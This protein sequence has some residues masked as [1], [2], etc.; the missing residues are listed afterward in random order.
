MIFSTLVKTIKNFCNPILLRLGKN[1]R[2]KSSQKETSRIKSSNFTTK[3]VIKTKY[4]ENGETILVPNI[5]EVKSVR[6][7]IIKQLQTN[8]AGINKGDKPP[9]A[10][11][12]SV[13][14]NIPTQGAANYK[15]KNYCV[16]II[17]IAC[18][19]VNFF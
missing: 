1:G 19:L 9:W 10:T 12:L 11:P 8:S 18:F 13:R 6:Q 16:E 15:F 3:T 17:V 2:N 4:R 14:D 7:I 5:I